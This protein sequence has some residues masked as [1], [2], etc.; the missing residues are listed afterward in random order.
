MA[1]L[2]TP[3]PQT[4][5]GKNPSCT[6]WAGGISRSGWKRGRTDSRDTNHPW[7]WV[8]PQPQ[9]Q[10]KAKEEKPA[11]AG[12]RGHTSS[13]GV[14]QGKVLTLEPFTSVARLIIAQECKWLFNPQALL[15]SLPSATCSPRQSKIGNIWM[16]ETL[17]PHPIFLAPRV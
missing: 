2:F 6:C 9:G 17:P 11:M 14:F 3:P 8:G 1:S 10:Q 4:Q 7:L 13:A 5:Q 16:L 12:M 15:P